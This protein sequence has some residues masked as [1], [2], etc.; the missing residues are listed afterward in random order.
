M[1]R[2]PLHDDDGHSECVACLDKSHADGVL[3]G[4]SCPHCE[5]MSL[6]SLRSRVAFF[7]EAD[8]AA[9]AL[10]SPSSREPARK[11]QRGR[12]TQRPELCKLTSSQPPR[13]SPSPPREQSPVMF[14]RPEQRPSADV[15][16][17]VSFGGSD[18]EPDDSMSLAASEAEGW[19]GELDDPAPLPPLEPI[20]HGQGM[21]AELFRILSRAVGDF[22]PYEVLIPYLREPRLREYSIRLVNGNTDCSGRVEILYDGQWGTVC[23]DGWDMN[24]AEVVCRQ[25]GCGPAARAHSNARFG[26]GSGR[27]WLS[28]VGCSGS[29]SSLTQCSHSPLGNHNCGHKDDAGVVCLKDI[30]LVSGSDSCCGRVEIL[31]NGQWGTVCDDDWDVNDAAVVCRQLECGSAISAPKSAAFGQGSGSIWL[32]GVGCSGGEGNLTQCSHRGL[33][34]HNCGHGK[35]AAV[36]CSG[37]LQRP[38]LFLIST[39]AVS[40]AVVSP[41]QNIRFRCTTPEPRCNADAEFHLF[42]NGSSISSQKHVSDVTF[43]LV[44]VSVSHQGSYSCNYT[45][46]NGTVISPWSN[47]VDITVGEYSI[48]LVNGNT[49]CSGRVEILYDDQ[50]GTVCDD[51]WDM[52]DAEVVCRQLGCGPAARAHSNARFG[53]GSGRIWL[54]N[55]GCSG[56]ESS[57]TQCSHSPLGNHSCRHNEDAGVVCLKDIRL[58][59]GS[60]SCCGRVEILHNGQWGTVCDNDWD[61]ND[62]AVVCRQ[63][64]CGSAISAPKSSAFGQGSGSIWLD[65]VGCSGGEGNLTQCSHRGLGAHNCGHGKDAAVVCSEG[66]EYSIRLVNGN[67]DCSGRVEILYDDQWGTVCDDGWDMND[68]E[69]VCRQLGCGPAARAHSNAR[70][71]QGSGRIWLSNVRCSGSESSLTQCSHS[72]LGNHNCGHKDD[73]GVVC[74]KDIR[75]VSGSDS[76]CGRVEILHNGQ[77]GTVCDNDWD[78]NDAAVVC[79]QLECGSAISAPKSAAFGQGSGSIWLDGVGCSGGEGNLTQCSHRGLGAHNCGHGKDAAV[80]CSGDLQRPTLFLIS[81]NA[82]SRAVVSRAVVSP[83]QNIQ[84]RCTTPEPRCNAD[85]EFHLFINGSSISSQKHVSDVTFHLVNVSVSHQGSYSCY[86]SY[87][88]GAV[89]SPWSNTVDITVG[90]YSI[91]LVNGNTDCSGRVEILYDG[92]WGTVCDDGWDMNDAEVVCRQLGCGPAARAHSNA[93]FGQGSGRIWLSYV[94]CSGSESSLTQCSHSPLGNHNC[95]HNE[96][97]GVVCLKDIRLVSGSDS[98]CGRVEILHNGQWGTVCDNDWDMNDAA[99][100]CRQLECGS[101]ISAPK[102]AAF[103]QGSGS[104]WLDGVGCSGDEGNLTQCSHRGL[105]AYN[106]G[107]GKDAAVVC[108][109]DLWQPTLSLISTNA[110]S[111]AVVSPGQNIQFR[112]T[113]TKPRCNADAEF[114]LFINGSSIS[115]QKHVSDVTFHLVNVSVSHQGSYSCNYTYHNGTVISPW[116]NTVDITVGEYTIRLV[117]GST[118]CSGRVEILYDDQWGTVCDDDWDIEDAEVVCRQLGCGRAVSA[119]SE[120]YFGQGSDPIWLDYLQ[121]SGSESS[122]TQCSHSLENHNCGHEEDAG[123]VCLKDIRLVSGSD[124]CCGRVEI[125]HNGQWG[126]VCDNDWDVNDAAVVCRQLECGSAISAPKSAAFGQGSGSIW[127]DDVG[128]S[129]GEGN[130]TQCSHRGLGAHNCG[131]GEDAAVV[132]SGDLRQ[133]TLSV[134][135]THAVVSPG[136]NIQFR[137]T[138]PKPRCNAD[139]EFHLFINESSISSQKHVS[140]VTFHLVNVSVSHQGSYSCNYSYQNGTVISPW[141]NTVNI[142]VGEYTIRLVNGSNNC[143]GRVEILYDD[144]WGTVCDDGWDIEDAEVVC[145]QL[146]CGRAVSANSEA[147]FG[148]GSDPIWLDDVEC[149]GSES[150]LT[151]CSQ[152]SLGNHNCGH[153]EDAGVVCLKVHLQQPSIHCIAPDGRFDVEPQ[154]PVIPSGHN[155]TIICSTE[156]QYPGGSFHLFRESNITRSQT[157]VRHSA[158]FSFPEAH[159]SHEGNYSC[160]YEVILSSRTFRSSASEP[161]VITVTGGCPDIE[162]GEWCVQD[163]T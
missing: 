100:V 102:S 36:V 118:N 135:P 123:V 9:R 52:N 77:W 90:E 38:T 51:G 22:S 133:P 141:S 154:G 136:E 81:T 25:L 162:T 105:G 43:H 159:C 144:Q 107:H 35:D 54:S 76:C 147:Y 73:A 116:S 110:V 63:L 47:T 97:A 31:H 5:S 95:R 6:G 124:S 138:T 28:Y 93:R 160:V 108:S 122:L 74:L 2:A 4:A 1:C 115:S 17:L 149:S 72:P 27:T 14:S 61:V 15:S 46:H 139:A 55:V 104:I 140:D 82:V 120:A 7:T 37:Y 121:C 34:A 127:L 96:D 45:Y 103:G 79:R 50:W 59:S 92:Q 69:V 62:A 109:G 44:N 13:A 75:L 19:A 134:I 56:S 40:R 10:P 53:Q 88:N 153:Q 41:G 111:R 29:E 12:A 23:D 112:C 130:L 98:C 146:G 11:R 24:D 155:F 32:D 66:G 87:H 158:S 57:L 39:N 117:N 125:L 3:A 48:R 99:V 68:A 18:E 119:H 84:F 85:A 89:I 8:L 42:I 131:H 91:R 78:V 152:N 114:H 30:R 16:D 161:L 151:Q 143:S 145:R 86:Y 70:F 26:Q 128:C 113:T 163:R 129:G 80:V 132:C 150:S 71:G 137:C 65:G 94:R 156:S 58:V 60:D 20:D 157:A 67:T 83:G 49:D 33:G 148:Q 142:T 64:E 101:A 106:C 21:D 126:T